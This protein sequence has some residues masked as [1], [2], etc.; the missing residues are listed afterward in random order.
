MRFASV[1]GMKVGEGVT[2]IEKLVKVGLMCCVCFSGLLFDP[3][4]IQANLS[5]SIMYS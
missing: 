5:R 4:C 1:A 3:F 2:A